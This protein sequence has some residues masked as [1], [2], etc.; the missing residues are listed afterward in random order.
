MFKR[1]AIFVLSVPLVTLAGALVLILSQPPARMLWGLP[2]G[3][4]ARGLPLVV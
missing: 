1:A 2:P 4:M 3:A